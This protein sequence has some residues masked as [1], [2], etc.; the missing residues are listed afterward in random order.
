MLANVLPH[1]VEDGGAYEAVLD[2][3]RKEKWADILNKL[4]HDVDTTA[5]EARTVVVKT[6]AGTVVDLMVRGTTCE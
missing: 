2:G 3:A 6:P 5:L 1:D 4:T